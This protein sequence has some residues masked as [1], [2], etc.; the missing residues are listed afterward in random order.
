[1]S[2]GSKLCHLGQGMMKVKSNCFFCLLQ[3]VWTHIYI[4]FHWC[5][6][7]FLKTWSSTKPVSFVGDCLNQSFPGAP[8]ITVRGAELGLWSISRIEVY[9]T[10]TCQMDGWQYFHVPLHVVLDLKSPLKAFLSMNHVIFLLSSRG[11]NE[12]RII[13][14]WCWCHPS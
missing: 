7:A 10:V 3:C 6:G 8:G 2:L 12:R 13:L 1:M 11:W 4:L 9:L 5:A 14:P